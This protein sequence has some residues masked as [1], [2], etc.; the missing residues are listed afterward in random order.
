MSALAPSLGCQ[1]SRRGHALRVISSGGVL[2]HISPHMTLSPSLAKTKEGG[3][4]VKQRLTRELLLVGV[5]FVSLFCCSKT[6]KVESL[7]ALGENN[8]TKL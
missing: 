2:G 3:T 5:L 6:A 4:T 8:K 1:T 7:N